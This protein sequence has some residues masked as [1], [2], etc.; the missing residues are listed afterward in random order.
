[1][2]FS[3]PL[4]IRFWDFSRPS[5]HQFRHQRVTRTKLED[6]KFTFFILTIFPFSRSF[7]CSISFFYFSYFCTSSNVFSFIWWNNVSLNEVKRKSAGNSS[8]PYFKSTEYLLGPV[9]VMCSLPPFFRKKN[10][11]FIKNFGTWPSVFPLFITA[12]L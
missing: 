10:V 4:V 6:K 2:E 5:T 8:S 12:M 11:S 7:S 1:M 9:T 3:N